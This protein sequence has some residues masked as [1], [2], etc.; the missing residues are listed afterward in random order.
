MTTMTT[1]HAT[2]VALSD[3]LTASAAAGAKVLTRLYGSE[4]TPAAVRTACRVS[5]IL[6]DSG[7]R[8]T[9]GGSAAK[10]NAI[11][12]GL[13]TDVLTAQGVDAAYIDALTPATAVDA[14]SAH[15]YSPRDLVSVTLAVSAALAAE[16]KS[17]REARAA[18]RDALKRTMNDRGADVES[19]T[20]A[21]RALIDG[22]AAATAV[23]GEEAAAA[24]ATAVLA[25]LNKGA[26]VEAIAAAIGRT[27]GD[28]RADALMAALNSRGI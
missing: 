25:A 26:T 28:T 6:H 15:E 3:A 7:E 5:R 21:A 27:V 9:R 8:P 12:M 1:A 13:A 4:A 20:A 16:Q 11:L 14:L 24:A 23:K 19:R 22:D 17:I 10:I 2:T 18:E